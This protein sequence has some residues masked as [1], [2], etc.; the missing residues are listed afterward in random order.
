MTFGDVSSAALIT[1]D[2]A[3]ICEK[4]KVDKRY[5]YQD[6]DI[7]VTVQLFYNW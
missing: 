2:V 3:P 6:C 1:A 4:Y 5:G 7:E